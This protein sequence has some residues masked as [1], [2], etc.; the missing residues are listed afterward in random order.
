ML[1]QLRIQNFKSWRDTGQMRFAPLTGFFGANSSGKSS[2]LQFL[3]MLKQT[4]ESLDRRQILDLGEERAYVNLGTFN[5]IVYGHDTP[6]K[7]VF[8][9]DWFYAMHEHRN[10]ESRDHKAQIDGQLARVKFEASIIDFEGFTT[11][12]YF[13]YSFDHQ[14]VGMTRASMTRIDVNPDYVLVRE[15]NKSVDT[16]VI[17]GLPPPLQFYRFPDVIEE[18]YP[19]AR[20]LF[21]LSSN[22]ASQFQNIYYLGPLR[23][24]PSRSY[25][26]SGRWPG[27]LGNRGELAIPAMIASKF[28]NARIGASGGHPSEIETVVPHWL[29]TLGLIDNLQIAEVREDRSEYEVRVRLSPESPE[30]NIAEVGFGVSQVLPVLALCYFAPIGSTLILEQP[31]IHLHPAVQAGL[32]DVFIDVIKN[33]NIQIILES[34]SEHLLVRL[35][36]RIAEEELTPDDVALYFTRMEDGASRL[37]ELKLDSYGNISN[38]PQDFFGDMMGDLVKM[39]EAAMERQMLQGVSTATRQNGAGD[40]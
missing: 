23:E 3:L 8:S 25:L 31:E 26:W 19:E 21:N 11:V 40:A 28:I 22:L 36:R 17:G 5:D 33:R 10:G 14:Q 27:F 18:N 35:Q 34:H 24:Y 29:K 37:E 39:T 13:H 20:Q 4:I 6:G 15:D 16:E 30:V 2:I 9:I 7:I 38:W 12:E 32:A 1:T